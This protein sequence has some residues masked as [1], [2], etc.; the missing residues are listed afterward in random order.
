MTFKREGATMAAPLNSA[1]YSLLEHKFGSVRIANEGAPAH[2]QRFPDPFNPGKF[3]TRAQS[4]G[5]YYCVC[6]PFCNDADHKLWIN[7]RYGAEYDEE[8]GRRAD[9][10]LACCYKNDCVKENGRSVQLEQLIF[11]PGRP[12][13]KKAVIRTA[14]INLADLELKAPGL[15]RPLSELP[16]DHD[17]RVY[18][19]N[20]GFD[21]DYLAAVFDLGLCEAP[22]AR[23]EIM[24][25]RVYIPAYFNRKLV[26]WQ[27]RLARDAKSK[28]EIKYYT[29]G[30]KS[31]ALY[32]YDNACDQDC[33]VVVEG[34]PSAWRLGSIGVSLFGKTLSYWQE[35]TIATTWSGKPVFV[36]L[37]DDAAQETEKTISK[38]RQHNLQVVPVFLPDERDPA[39]Y[40]RAALRD[41]LLHAADTAAVAAG[42]CLDSLKEV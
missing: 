13:V 31:Q 19:A 32:N 29:Q 14:E 11:G 42:N 8:K 7:H 41:L 1:L 2:I 28:K 10:Y 16:A 3:V 17:A 23:Y 15:I 34:A 25:D 39:D 38:L 4:W 36:L 5:E 18:L 21:P 40:T 37:D 9:T 30:K 26:A 35:N 24:R 20:R 22:T 6:C 12:I 33:V 27:G